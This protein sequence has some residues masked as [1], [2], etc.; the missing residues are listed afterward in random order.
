MFPCGGVGTSVSAGSHEGPA[1]A[2]QRTSRGGLSGSPLLLLLLVL[3]SRPLR[4]HWTEPSEPSPHVRTR[5][6]S[7]PG[8]GA[9]HGSGPDTNLLGKL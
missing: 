2:E 1:A 7:I 4:T 8:G 3:V 6:D 9:A 5:S